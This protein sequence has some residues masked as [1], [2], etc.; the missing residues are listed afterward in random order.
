MTGAMRQQGRRLT[1]PGFLRA[2][3]PRRHAEDE[4]VEAQE[5]AYRRLIADWQASR[6]ATKAGAGAGATPGAHLKGPR[7]AKARG[8][9]SSPRTL[10]FASSVTHTH[11]AVAQPEAPT[12]RK[13]DFHP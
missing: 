6:P 3:D 7:S 8:R 12:S 2:S 5:A 9:P 11:P 4:L 13:L 10:R 1:E